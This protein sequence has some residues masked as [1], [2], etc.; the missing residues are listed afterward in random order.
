[1]AKIATKVDQVV[2][3]FYVRDLD[4]EKVDDPKQVE[5]IKSTVMAEVTQ[6]KDNPTTITHNLT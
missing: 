5:R 6:I 2:D 3:V 1:V 4:G